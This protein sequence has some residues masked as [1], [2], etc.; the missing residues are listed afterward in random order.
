MR[1]R[2][3][4]EMEDVRIMRKI[5]HVSG[6]WMTDESAP[7]AYSTF[8]S[9]LGQAG[10]NAGFIEPVTFGMIRRMSMNV[11]VAANRWGESQRRLAYGHT[12]TS[13][14]DEVS[15]AID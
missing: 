11:V 13:T 9:K 2:L 3:R 7:E 8:T 4:P 1:L 15:T 6:S 12:L 10:I 14:M 5:S